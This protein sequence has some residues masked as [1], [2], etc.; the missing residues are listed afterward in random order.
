MTEPQ[1]AAAVLIGIL[2]LH[3]AVTYAASERLNVFTAL[4]M[5]SL[6]PATALGTLAAVIASFFAERTATAVLSGLAVF[7]A[8]VL[9]YTAQGV[10]EIVSR[11][12]LPRA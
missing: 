8:L 4:L 10:W 6:L 5:L 1:I 12:R 9:P 3:V 7:A 11:R 2:A